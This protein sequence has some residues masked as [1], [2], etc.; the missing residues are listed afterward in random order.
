MSYNLAHYRYSVADDS[1]VH[2]DD[3]EFLMPGLIDSHIHA[4]QYP[5]AGTDCQ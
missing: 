4:S 5:N 1:V 2:L 3:N